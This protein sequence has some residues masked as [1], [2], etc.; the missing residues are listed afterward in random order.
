MD[1]N[2][3]ELAG[4]AACWVLYCTLHS[5]LIHPPVTRRLQRWLGPRAGAYRFCFNVFSLV[6]LV[7]LVSWHLRLRGPWIVEW[8]GP[9]L[10]VPVLLNL[11]ALVLVVLGATAYGS[12]D[13]LGLASFRAALGGGS[14]PA[15]EPFAS[16]G[17]L[18]WVRHPW[19]TAS[20]LLVW[21]HDMDAGGLMASLVLTVY[22]FVGTWL[23][24]RK[25]ASQFGEAYREYQRQVPMFIPR[26]PGSKKGKSEE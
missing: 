12:S 8:E 23:E 19:Y 21:G 16:R 18:R 20:F 2:A 7:P 1:G 3:L 26:R 6:A 9:W 4:L 25:L 22:L 13:F 10:A 5:L 15:G 14:A 24:E 17:I 11:S